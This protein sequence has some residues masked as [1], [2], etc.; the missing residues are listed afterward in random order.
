MNSGG[1]FELSYLNL[2]TSHSLHAIRTMTKVLLIIEATGKQGGTVID[3]LLAQPFDFTIL[4]VTRDTNSASAQK[5]AAKPPVIKLIQHSLDDIPAI[6]LA[7]SKAT[8][9]SM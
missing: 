5:F 3:A 2:S 7:A 9:S 1:V 6:F 8:P 4:V